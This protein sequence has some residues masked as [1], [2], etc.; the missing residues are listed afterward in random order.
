MEWGKAFLDHSKLTIHWLV[1]GSSG[2]L[3][4]RVRSRPAQPSIVQP[5]QSQQVQSLWACTGSHAV[6]DDRLAIFC[7]RTSRDCNSKRRIAEDGGTED[8]GSK[9]GGTDDG[10]SKDGG[11]E[12]SSSEDD[13][14]EGDKDA[15]INETNA[16]DNNKDSTTC[17]QDQSKTYSDSI[18][19]QNVQGDH[20][21]NGNDDRED[22]SQDQNAD[23]AKATKINPLIQKVENFI[24][25]QREDELQSCIRA[26]N[27][28]LWKGPRFITSAQWHFDWLV[29]SKE[30]EPVR[31]VI[32]KMGLHRDLEKQIEHGARSGRQHKTFTRQYKDNVMKISLSSKTPTKDEK[33][34]RRIFDIWLQQGAVLHKLYSLCPGFMGLIAP[35]LKTS[36]Y[37]LLFVHMSALILS[38]EYK[39]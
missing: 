27:P 12:D 2:R 23:N 37:G 14:T 17:S 22:D 3:C 34:K 38:T 28:S 18:H 4:V 33:A 10:G 19:I 13:D 24:S 9:D 15:G 35:T 8:G 6:N 21:G 29:D 32:H 1:K 39:S 36:E 7:R 20:N 31:K 11:T 5:S 26:W 25:T 30:N 16:T